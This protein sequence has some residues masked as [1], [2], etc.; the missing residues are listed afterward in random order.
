TSPALKFSPFNALTFKR[1]KSDLPNDVLNS[2]SNIGASSPDPSSII[3]IDQLPAIAG[4]QIGLFQSIGLNESLIWPTGIFQHVFEYV[5]VYTGLPWWATIIG[6]TVGV[7]S[8]M[9]PI[10]I[11]SAE[12][13]MKMAKIKPEI[14]KIALEARSQDPQIVQQ[15]MLKQHQLMQSN[16][17]KPL[18]MVKPMLGV[19]IFFGIFNS[20]RGMAS[21]PVDGFTTQG[22]LWFTNLA[23]SDPYCLLQTVTA[24][25]YALSFK[26]LGNELS[27]NQNLNGNTMK[28]LSLIMPFIAVPLT[29]N[30]PAGICLY[31]AVNAICA[32]KGTAQ[33]IL[34]GKTPKDCIAVLTSFDYDKYV[35]INKLP[36]RSESENHH[37][38]L[39]VKN[40]ILIFH[41]VGQKLSDSYARVNFVYAIDKLRIQISEL[42]KSA[43][44][45]EKLANLDGRFLILPVNWRMLI[46]HE[47][48]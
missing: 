31:F 17:I 47:A 22:L 40:L 35:E 18:N 29:R 21:V 4:D 42:I 37:S 3:P 20:L 10:Y 16:K 24:S 6:V 26:F 23:A 15:A 38:T 14:E 43:N 7:R 44:E 45:D 33:N 27:P 19:P 30:L 11:K 41:G 48:Q 1:Y 36:L 28:R 39:P 25:L 12:T 13:N 9:L 5:H 46:S 8:L 32:T 34:S 2:I